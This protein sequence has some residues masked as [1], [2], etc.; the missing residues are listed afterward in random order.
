MI[1]FQTRYTNFRERD[2]KIEIV[3]SIWADVY[4]LQMQHECE[5]CAIKATNTKCIEKVV[6]EVRCVHETC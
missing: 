4:K 2:I 3:K 5:L 1:Q 6:C